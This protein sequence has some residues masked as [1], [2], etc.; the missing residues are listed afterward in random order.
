MKYLTA[1][2]QGS[3]ITSLIDVAMEDIPDATLQQINDKL[4][5]ELCA[6]C[7]KLE[8]LNVEQLARELVLCN[9]YANYIVPMEAIRSAEL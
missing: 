6:V 8:I 5:I 7:H 4:F 1:C 2:L 3:P 9:R